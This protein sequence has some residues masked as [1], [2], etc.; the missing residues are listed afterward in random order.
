MNVY[1][2]PVMPA[3]TGAEPPFELY[4][5]PPPDPEPEPEDVAQRG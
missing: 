3:P 2:L 5:E 4:C 1:L